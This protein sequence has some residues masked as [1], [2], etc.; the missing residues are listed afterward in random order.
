MQAHAAE[1]VTDSEKYVEQLLGQYSTFS[2]LVSDAFYN[3]S[4]FLTIR[5]KAFQE[6]VNNTDVFRIELESAEGTSKARG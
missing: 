5:D 1:I 3:D 2:Q 6:V 4:R